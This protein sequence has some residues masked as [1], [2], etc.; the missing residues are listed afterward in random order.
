MEQTYKS[1]GSW[2]RY[3]P[4]VPPPEKPVG[5]MYAKRE[6]DGMDWYDYAHNP[7]NWTEGSAK[8]TLIEAPFGIQVAATATD[9]WSLFPQGCTVLEVI[10]FEGDAKQF[11]GKL[12]D[13]DN[14]TFVDPPVPPAVTIKA[15]IWR[16]CTDEEAETL[17]NLL[18][19]LPAKKRNL[20]ND[21]NFLAHD[22]PFFDE[23][24][25][26]VIHAIG[27]ERA[28]EVLGAS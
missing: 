4:E 22:D 28:S 2:T 6:S 9:P 25:T 16:R 21:C 23:L 10:G 1:H 13:L 15:D 3:F 18:A 27:E 8:L 12:V 17:S 24:A 20:Y 19:A 14:D 26:A 11:Q 5:T 7:E